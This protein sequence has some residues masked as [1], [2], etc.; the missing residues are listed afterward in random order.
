MTPA[1]IN[2][3]NAFWQRSVDEFE[4]KSFANSLDDRRRAIAWS[5]VF[6]VCAI[7]TIVA[8]VAR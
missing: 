3:M 2:K 4:R 8:G 6:I 5:I 1:E 7:V